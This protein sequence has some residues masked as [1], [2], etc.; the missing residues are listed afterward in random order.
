MFGIDWGNSQTLWLNLTNLALGIV[1]VLALGVVA[2]GVA[3]EVF[4]KRRKAR[5]FAGMD[6]E[7]RHMLRVPEL[8]LTMADGGEPLP[9]PGS[10]TA[11]ERKR[12]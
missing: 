3:Q 5:Q 6:E 12:S 8:G 11:P 9:S 10:D 7:V 1:T 4:E 2:F